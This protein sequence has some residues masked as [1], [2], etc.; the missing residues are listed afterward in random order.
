MSKGL[1]GDSNT[2]C[3]S[4]FVFV[5]QH[6]C[7]RHHWGISTHGNR[8]RLH[9]SE[10]KWVFIDICCAIALHWSAGK[11]QLANDCC[12]KKLTLHS[13]WWIVLL[14]CH[15]G[16]LMVSRSQQWT[17]VFKKVLENLWKYVLLE[18]LHCWM[19]G[20][21]LVWNWSLRKVIP[22]E[23]RL[24]AKKCLWLAVLF[25]NCQL[26]YSIKNFN[27]FNHSGRLGGGPTDTC[28]PMGHDLFPF[29]EFFSKWY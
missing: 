2:F 19:F 5:W 15:F 7:L 11:I 12:I 3:Y 22:L 25:D 9:K 14:S 10:R 26:P 13:D 8:W 29:I 17:V 20:L 18:L 21:T 28:P 24:A 23:F 16:I 1:C 6:L 27:L 4:K